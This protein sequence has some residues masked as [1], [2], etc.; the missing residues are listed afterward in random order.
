MKRNLLF[1]IVVAGFAGLNFLSCKKEVNPVVASRAYLSLPSHPYHYS[2][3]NDTTFDNVV[4]LGRVLFYDTHLS[5]NGAIA[6][7][8]CHRQSFAFSDNV[9]FSR[10]FENRITHRNAPPIENLSVTGVIFDPGPGGPQVSGP[11]LFWDGREKSL[12]SMVLKP[13]VNHVEMGMNDVNALASRVQQLSY[14]KDLF[15]RA[16]SDPDVNAEKIA[17]ALAAFTGNIGAVNTKFDQFQGQKASLNAL[18]T[19]GLNLFMD[20]YDCGSCH[21]LNSFSYGQESTFLNIGLDQNYTDNGVGALNGNPADNGK[22][23]VP[24]LR[25]VLLTAP[26]MHD[27]RFASLEDVLEHYSEGIKD[28]PNLDARLRGTDHQPRK[29]NISPQEKQALIA[30]LGTLTDYSLVTDIRYSNPFKVK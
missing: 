28:H 26:Y 7:A 8:S 9:S 18:E 3:F 25:N 19:Q 30:F 13:I 12:N 22:F 23:K 1:L 21:Q 20:K 10:G 29:M 27:G 5:V 15:S 4:T 2:S 11:S 16:F 6:C 17:T 14:Y 24:N